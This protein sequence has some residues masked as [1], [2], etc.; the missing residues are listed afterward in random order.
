MAASSGRGSGISGLPVE[1]GVSAVRL[2]TDPGFTFSAAALV[3]CTDVH[4]V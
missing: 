3:Q 4:F 2:G 1:T